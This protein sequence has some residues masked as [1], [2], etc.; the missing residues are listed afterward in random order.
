MAWS[1]V[2]RAS[3]VN[4]ASALRLTA[5]G[6]RR[7]RV[8]VLSIV[9]AADISQWAGPLSLQE[10][11][12]PPQHA[13]RVE[14]GGVTVDELGKVLTPTQVWCGPA[15]GEAGTQR[16]GAG[17]EPRACNSDLAAPATRRERHPTTGGL[18]CNLMSRDCSYPQGAAC[19]L[20]DSKASAFPL[21]CCS[22][23]WRWR[24]GW[25]ADAEERFPSSRKLGLT[26]L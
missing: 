25:D 21:P 17:L 14:Y 23:R 12:E 2:G 4:S 16:G 13:L 8:S 20:N 24:W 5:L 6:T 22:W 10:V 15:G 18:L 19:T 9:M 11:D 3:W 26:G 1:A 7:A